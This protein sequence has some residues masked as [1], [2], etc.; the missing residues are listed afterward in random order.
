MPLSQRRSRLIARLR[1]RRSREREGQVLVEGVRAVREALDCGVAVAFAVVSPKLL[2]T[3]DGA[4]LA[5]RLAG[6]DV[7]EVSDDDLAALA[8]TVNP[9]GV[10]LVCRQPS[11]SLRHLRAGRLLVLDAVQDPGNVGT[12]VRAAVAFG[13]DGIVCL[14][15]TVDPWSAKV[16]RA[17]AGTVFRSPPASA[18]AE[19][20]SPWLA[21]LHVPLLVADAGGEDVE[22]RRGAEAFALVIG[23]EGEGVRAFLRASADAIVAVPMSGPVESL[24]AGVAGSILMHTLTRSPRSLSE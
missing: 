21:E 13:L 20:V 2:V 17:S 19:D 11:R 10:L 18:R 24:N 4:A 12:L 15:G 8:D 7:E 3:A 23:N 16:V 6:H 9:Q 14:D 5:R 22:G 1:A